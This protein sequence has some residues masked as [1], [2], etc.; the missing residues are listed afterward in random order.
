MRKTDV[1]LITRTKDIFDLYLNQSAVPEDDTDIQDIIDD[2]HG[3][4]ADILFIDK[5]ENDA[6]V[7]FI[8]GL[9]ILQRGRDAPEIM[10]TLE[11]VREVLSTYN[12]EAD[13]TGKA[14]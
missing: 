2:I 8:I 11:D 4:L 6:L 10:R 9:I 14:H 13:D 5:V 1:E 12:F 7:N 3:Q